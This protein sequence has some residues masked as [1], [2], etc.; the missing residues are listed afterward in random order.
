MFGFRGIRTRGE[1][2]DVTEQINLTVLFKDQY[3]NSV[4]TDQLP[5]ISIIQPNGSV[6]LA[7]TSQ[8]ITQTSTGAYSYL[9]TVPINGPYGVF[10]DVWAATINGFPAGNT[11]NFV[12]SNTQLPALTTLDG[13]HPIRALGDDPGFH[14]SQIAIYNINKLIKMLKARLNSDGA[15]PAFD[16]FGNLQYVSCSLYSIDVLTTFL[17]TSLTQFNGIPYFTFFTFDDTLFV[18]QWAEILVQGA[19]IYALASKALIEKGRQFTMSDDGVSFTP[20]DVSEVLQ[21]QFGTMLTAY[22]DQLKYIKNSLRP[23]PKTL[24]VFN[25]M[26]GGL[27]P[28]I[29]R[30]RFLKARR[31]F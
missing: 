30:L 3:G 25:I 10:N 15:T 28:A 27:S 24:G 29:S 9:F 20:P 31:I 19:T 18:E 26:A 22:I 17:S 2:V 14:Y 16:N 12:V 13:Y 7:P 11:F 21:S 1:F 6:L 8:G 5:T 4:N 23:S